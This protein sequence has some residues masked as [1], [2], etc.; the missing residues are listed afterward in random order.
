MI[1][2]LL[3]A[4][5]ETYENKDFQLR[6]RLPSAD[7]A[8]RTQEKEFT[9]Q[10]NG[11]LCEVASKDGMIGGV[12]VHYTSAMR[13]DKYADWREG[14]WSKTEGVKSFQRVHEKKIEGKPKGQWLVREHQMEY[15]DY[16]YRYLQ[17][18][19]ADGKHNFELALWVSE[20]LWEEQKETLYRIVNSVS[21]G[22]ASDDP[23]PGPDVEVKDRR[24]VNRALGLHATGPESFAVR[25]ADFQF[26]IQNSIAEF[27][28]DDTAAVIGVQDLG[29]DAA[30]HADAFQ[31][32]IEKAHQ[33]FKR[34][35]ET[36]DDRG[37][38][39]HD[40]EGEKD[41]ITIRYA[42]LFAVD[43]KRNYF[44]VAWMD[45]SSWEK[46]RAEVD[47]L[48]AS[49]TFFPVETVAIPD[50][51][52][53]LGPGSWVKYKR[54]SENLVRG[55]GEPPLEIELL[56]VLVDQ[57]AESYTVR[58]DTV[59]RGKTTEGKPEK[60]LLRRRK[61]DE[62][63][64]KVEEGEETV[65]VPKGDFKCR[66][67]KVTTEQGW[68]KTW[69]SDAVPLGLV[70]SQSLMGSDSTIVELVDFEKK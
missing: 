62:P 48:L 69:T 34:V 22:A 2:L 17:L 7:F 18:F 23:G 8:L 20:T 37:R 33:K 45:A 16:D 14:A 12:L 40:Y 63:K 50:P 66:W 68:T 36:K 28:T 46:R 57:D 44:F 26:G 25:G 70:K 1:P 38:V 42:A 15:N 13:V 3:L 27:E 56:H 21:Y 29:V 39:R 9:F 43:S 10:W 54:T 51:W 5:Q 11:T 60:V 53:G 52:K 30:A 59:V 24:Y 64:A 6:F 58:V 32:T 67:R 31:K 47:R 65:T 41:G 49:L 61:T 35:A 55:T 19:V 4:L